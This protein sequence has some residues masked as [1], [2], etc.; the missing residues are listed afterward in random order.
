MTY[1]L[2]FGSLS[3][4]APVMLSFLALLLVASTTFA[5]DLSLPA[6]LFSPLVAQKIL[7]TAT[8]A[9]NPPKYPQWT[10]RDT[11]SWQYFSPDTW[12]TGFFPV[13]LYALQERLALCPT[14][15]LKA[16]D[17]LSLAQRW[18]SAEVPLETKT[19]V[20]HD[21]GFL[22]FPFIEELSL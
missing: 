16:A 8:T 15:D 11:G 5:S 6:E 9:Q 7:A 12:T 13:T 22:S 10:D 1:P 19:G 14:D 20:G 18:S 2:L 3:T 21:V 4:P 17:W